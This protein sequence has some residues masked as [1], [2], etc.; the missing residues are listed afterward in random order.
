M[1]EEDG[2]KYKEHKSADAGFKYD[3]ICCCIVGCPK[4]QDYDCSDDDDRADHDGAQRLK[5]EL[6]TSFAHRALAHAPPVVR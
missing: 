5:S 3:F 1:P 2:R 6:G 4:K